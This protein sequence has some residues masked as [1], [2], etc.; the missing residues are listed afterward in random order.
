MEEV[1]KGAL[2]RRRWY[3]DEKCVKVSR[4]IMSGMP[5]DQLKMLR[6]LSCLML[7]WTLKPSAL[8][9]SD[10]RCTQRREVTIGTS[11]AWH[12]G[13]EPDCF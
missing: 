10:D 7:E 1:E 5:E 9:T 2:R 11:K 8:K 13:A 3:T 6:A 4:L 12:R